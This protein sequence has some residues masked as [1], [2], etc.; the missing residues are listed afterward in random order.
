ME[1]SPLVRA[2][3]ARQSAPPPMADV[4]QRNQPMVA[5]GQHSYNTRLAPLEEME[6]RKWLSANRVPFDPEAGVTDY[7]MRGFFQALKQ[8]NPR[9]VSAVDPH[10]KQMH[11]PDYWKTPYHDT[12]SRESQW[13]TGMAPAW[14]DDGR[15]LANASGRVLFDSKTGR[16][17]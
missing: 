4:F 7:D 13:A 17:P 12:F 1:D 3:M 10:D 11:Y 16:R 8:G 6:F 14:S 2:M 9:A 15:Y 5:P